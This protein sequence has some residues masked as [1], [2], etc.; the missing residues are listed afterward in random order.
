MLRTGK[1]PKGNHGLSPLP[2]VAINNRPSIKIG[3]IAYDCLK[4]MAAKTGITVT[5]LNDRAVMGYYQA[6]ATGYMAG[7]DK[8]GEVFKQ[9]VR[10]TQELH[11]P[12]MLPGV[13]RETW[14]A[15]R[16]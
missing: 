4:E 16:S 13:K 10:D 9:S 14:K 12:G 15:G 1:L 8:G 7:L 6:F 11:H 3:S 2:K 5:D